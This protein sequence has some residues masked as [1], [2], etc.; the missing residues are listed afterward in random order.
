LSSIFLFILIYISGD[1][2]PFPPCSTAG[3]P[4][5]STAGGGG[6]GRALY[7]YN[8]AIFFDML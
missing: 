7:I 3:P 1:P 4:P 8:I 5:C 6:T 2:P